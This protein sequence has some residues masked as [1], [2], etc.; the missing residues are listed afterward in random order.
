VRTALLF[1]V[2][3]AAAPRLPPSPSPMSPRKI[4]EYGGIRWRDE[5]PRL[6]NYII[7]LRSDPTARACLI[8]YGGR[9][10]REGEARRRCERAAGYLKGVGGIDAARVITVDGGFREEVTVELWA[11]PAGATLPA[12][13]PTV[14][15]S[16]VKIIKDPPRRRRGR[17]KR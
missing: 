1:I 5:R 12:A 7:V 2:L 9:R 11:P 4:D 10:S 16:E 13:A 3:A 6:D 15:P 17:A 8:C 14:D